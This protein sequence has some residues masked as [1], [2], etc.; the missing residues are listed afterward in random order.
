M[1][2]IFPNLDCSLINLKNDFWF[3]ENMEI[4]LREKYEHE[5]KSQQLLGEENYQEIIIDILTTRFHM[6]E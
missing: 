6:I 4:K 1:K 5:I 2:T 3:V